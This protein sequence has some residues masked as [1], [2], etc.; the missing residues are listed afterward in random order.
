MARPFAIALLALFALTLPHPV[1][2]QDVV[3]LGIQN[4]VEPPA[5]VRAALERDPAA[6]RLKRVFRPQLDSVLTQKAHF[7]LLGVDVG[8]LA[9]DSAARLG[10]VMRGTLRVPVLPFLF[11]DTPNPPYAPAVLQ[12]KLFRPAGGSL[13]LTQL[14]REM[15]R[16]MFA[17]TGTVAPWVRVKVPFDTQYT[18]GP[19]GL[20]DLL[21]Q[22][23]DEADKQIDFRGFDHNND[24]IV[25]VVAFVQPYFGGECP[26][27]DPPNRNVWSHEWTYGAASGDSTRMYQTKDGVVISDYVI[28]PALNCDEKTPIDIGVFAHEFGHALGLP[29]LYSTTYPNPMNGGIGYW[30]L[31]GYGG[32][33]QPPSPAYMEAWSRAELGWLRVLP[34]RSGRSY[35]LDPSNSANG[36]ALRVSLPGSHGR[37][38]LL[39]NRQPL[40]ADRHLVGSGLLVW[41]VDSVTIANQSAFNAVQNTT[42]QRGLRLVEADG[43]NDLDIPWQFGDASDPYPGSLGKSELAFDLPG[44]NGAAVTLKNIRTLGQRVAFDLLVTTGTIAFRAPS[45][46]PPPAPPGDTL[47]PLALLRFRSALDSAD[48]RLLRAKGFRVL[49]LFEA[50]NSVFVTLPPTAR[51]ALSDI[52]PDL[53]GMTVQRR[54]SRPE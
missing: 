34:G 10:T 5:W 22:V 32:W 3:Q 52:H 48:F 11:A 40:G 51:G 49:R 47:G 50:S 14:Y 13:T 16:G 54:Q 12:D 29:D 35:V 17:V 45:P 41:E 43:G 23:L 25:D 39:E 26:R 4:R 30:G 36:Y 15:S 44:S 24:G 2:G 33:N 7:G 19:P 46:A 8:T 1:P 21:T 38:L 9:R 27:R 28:Q 18:A 53:V 6:L 42:S 20:G 37:Y 31:M